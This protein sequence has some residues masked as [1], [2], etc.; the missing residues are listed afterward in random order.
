MRSIDTPLNEGSFRIKFKFEFKET[1]YYRVA[2]LQDTFPAQSA[3]LSL[4]SQK[5]IILFYGSFEKY[6]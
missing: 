6:I 5:K 1:Q 2:S 4:V 3:I